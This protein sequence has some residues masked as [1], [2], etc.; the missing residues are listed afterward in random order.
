MILKS[1]VAHWRSLMDN[2]KSPKTLTRHQEYLMD[3][4]LADAGMIPLQFYMDKWG[5]YIKELEQC[6]G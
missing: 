5:E 4:A 1:T 2:S 3:K 6:T